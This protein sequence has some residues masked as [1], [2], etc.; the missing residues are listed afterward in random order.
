MNKIYFLFIF[1]LVGFHSFA[2]NARVQFI[3]NSPIPG[4]DG[5]PALDVYVN[6]S[7]YTELDSFTFRTATPFLEIIPNQSGQM[8]IVKIM[9]SPST[10]LDQP[11]AVSTLGELKA[12]SSYT[13]MINGVPLSI[14]GLPFIN[15]FVNRNVPTTSLSDTTISMNFFHG[16]I[17]V[18]P[19]QVRAQGAGNIYS[20]QYNQY[21]PY[22]ELEKKIYYLDVD[23]QNIGF[24]L[25]Y[26]ADLGELPCDVALM[27]IS[28]IAIGIPELGLFVVCE[29]GSISQL[30][31]TPIAR[32]QWVNN[33][34][35]SAYDIYLE[36]VKVISDLGYLEATLFD[37]FP[38]DEL[39]E[40]KLA[41]AGSASADEA[42]DT[43][44]VG[45]ENAKSAVVS[46]NGQLDHPEFPLIAG[47]KQGAR[48]NPLNPEMFEYTVGHAAPGVDSVSISI[49]DVGLLQDSIP[50]NTYTEYSSFNT[51]TYYMDFRS[52]ETDELIKTFI[53]NVT[54]DYIGK[55]M[56]MFLNGTLEDDGDARLW[57][58]WADGT[59]IEF[60]SLGY[61]RI[62][63]IH[64]SQTDSV[65]VYFNTE[66]YAENL[67][68]RTATKYLNIPS[69]IDINISVRPTGSEFADTTTMEKTFVFEEDVDYIMVLSGL[70]GDMVDSLQWLL[71]DNARII[72]E[73]PDKVDLLAFH[74]GKG[75]D[76]IDV[77]VRDGF[78]IFENVVYNG[79]SDYVTVDSAD[80]LLDINLNGIQDVLYSFFGEFSMYP[81][82]SITL[83]TSGTVDGDPDFTLLGILSD[84]TVFELP[85]RSF[86]YVQFINN[87]SLAVMD[88]YLNDTLYLDN[89]NTRN[90]T[91]YI[92]FEADTEFNFAFAPADSDGIDDAFYSID[93]TLD[94]G[95]NYILVATGSRNNAMFP[96][97]VIYRDDA[98]QFAGSLSTINLNFVHAAA[99]SQALTFSSLES[100]L[101]VDSL[102]Y[103]DFSDYMSL[104]AIYQLFRVTNAVDGDTLDVYEMDAREWA[105]QGV[106]ILARGYLSSAEFELLAILNDGTFFKLLTRDFSRIQFIN[107]SDTG[108][109][110]VYLNDNLWLND[111]DSDSATVFMNIVADRLNEFAIAPADSESSEDAIS[112]F[113]YNLVRDSVHTLYLTGGIDQVDFPFVWKMNNS[114]R[115]EAQVDTLIDMNIFHAA[116]TLPALSLNITNVGTWTNLSYTNFSNYSTRQPGK[117][118]IE[119]YQQT[120]LLNTYYVN[121]SDLGGE[122]LHFFIKSPDSDTTGIELSAALADGSIIDF[123][124]VKFTNVQ[125]L[126]NIPGLALDVYLDGFKLLD[127]MQYLSATNFLT[128]P[129]NIPVLLEWT[130][131][132]QLPMDS[133]G[134]MELSFGADSNYILIFNGLTDDVTYPLELLIYDEAMTEGIDQF[135]LEMAVFHGSPGTPPVD[136]SIRD[137]DVEF[138]NIAY[139]EIAPYT[140]VATSRYLIDISLTGADEILYTYE[141]NLIPYGGRAGVLFISGQI[142]GPQEFGLYLLLDNGTVI[143]F[144]Y[145][146]LAKIQLIHNAP[147]GNVDV[148]LG[149]EK[150]VTNMNFREA[151]P[152]I[153]LPAITPLVFGFA[154]PD[155]E[156]VSDTFASFTVILENSSNY[157]AMASGLRGSAETPFDLKIYDKARLEAIND[158]FID[159][160]KFNGIPDQGPLQIKIDGGPTLMDTLPYGE[161][162]DYSTYPGATYTLDLFQISSANESAKFSMPLN[163]LKGQAIT[164]FL[165][166][167]WTPEPDFEL[168]VALANG[169]TFPLDILSST[170]ELPAAISGLKL[171]PNPANQS[172]QLSLD[173]NT[174]LSDV[175]IQLFSLNGQSVKLIRYPNLESGS[176]S[177][178]I[179]VAEIVSGM[180]KVLLKS[181]QGTV[182]TSL[183]I[184]RH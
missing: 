10:I 72:A 99:V 154:E 170:S 184:L 140:S 104:D 142:E 172:A 60:E 24:L 90:A 113:E 6:D 47:G 18:P 95:R 46:I 36:D 134:F 183:L 161:F 70:A 109:K 81:G 89:Y 11:I 147:I 41:P 164:L 88:V 82:Q 22:A 62:Q 131:A 93:L 80:Y 86:A 180:Y 100:E 52:S 59:L 173:L 78:T 162:E 64:N 68:Y 129:A 76:A 15:V 2:Q 27:F 33:S 69:G 159:I 182:S 71:K 21:T 79:F 169:V 137:A 23:I 58:L 43:L 44:M 73:E 153:E 112:T 177:I 92:P 118:Y 49:K 144:V 66:L 35:E 28:G 4:T 148:Y 101:W 138:E 30:P 37:F 45:F 34:P 139:R 126:Q 117:Y 13:V 114:S 179:P 77:K 31:L 3:H 32:V 40:F 5:G 61:S 56:T 8:S 48:E 123:P 122:A 19:L 125:F 67:H 51:G 108:P 175:S 163:P 174:K 150:I 119:L 94:G 141:A 124:A 25:T 111:F 29:D 26:E 85:Q 171:Y 55:T 14:Q 156:S 53:I 84:G 106:T 16:G 54:E 83:M 178:E 128:I 151:T 96:F 102:A 20:A 50:Y 165:S 17:L 1:L 158:Q 135:D 110:D 63:L 12:D 181:D 98:K 65:D 149:E 130:P 103:G 146:P 155:S 152:F 143:P 132:G 75:L 7:L 120:D 39:L 57:G 168:W 136:I 91:P 145:K 74:G 157:I 166:G 115:E 87:A 160:L 116:H 167:L 121:L 38:A 9:L 42:V 105:G 127:S 133:L 107:T 176:K 97:E